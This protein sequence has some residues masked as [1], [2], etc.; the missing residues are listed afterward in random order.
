MVADPVAIALEVAA[1]FERAGVPYAI[2]GSLASMLWGEPRTTMDVDLVADLDLDHVD[3]LLAE[4]GDRF[5][6]EPDSVR[7][8][9]RARSMFHLLHRPSGFKVDVH[10]VR[11]SEG[12]AEEM[13]RR[14]S[15]RLRPGIEQTV[16][17]VS[18]EDTVLQ[19]LLW[20]RKGNEV[21]ERQ[22]RDVLGVLKQQRDR[23]DRTYLRLAAANL[24]V[25]DLLAR[26]IR[27]SGLSPDPS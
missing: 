20:Y 9:V 25:A 14:R 13:R 11:E 12:G 23:P 6:V 19:K 1:A 16:F 18:P 26:A 3:S 21:S 22:W 5:V 17:V 24:G 2:G 8:A 7:R 27:E 4:L 15:E 10:P